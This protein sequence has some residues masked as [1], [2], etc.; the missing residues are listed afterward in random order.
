MSNPSTEVSIRLRKS[1]PASQI[2]THVSAVYFLTTSIMSYSRAANHR[3]CPAAR[4]VIRPKLGIRIA[5][6]MLVQLFS[7]VLL[8]KVSYRIHHQLLNPTLD[9]FVIHS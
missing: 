3:S 5:L 6:I 8:L 9:R 4:A 1:A 2:E 7:L